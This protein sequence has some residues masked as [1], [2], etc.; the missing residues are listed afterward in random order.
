MGDGVFIGTL[1]VRR[2]PV[3]VNQL[4][5]KK[6]CHKCQLDS[7]P[8]YFKQGNEMKTQRT[9]CKCHLQEI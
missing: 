7:Q 9:C 3:N 8:R 5:V 2:G 6:T 1:N 4:T